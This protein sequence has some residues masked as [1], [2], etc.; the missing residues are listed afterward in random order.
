MS[1]EVDYDNLAR[2]VTVLKLNDS[3]VAR[4]F[5][6]CT[7]YRLSACC[8]IVD[9]TSFR[10]CCGYPPVAPESHRLSSFEFGE[11]FHFPPAR[12]CK[13]TKVTLSTTR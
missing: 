5:G 10:H 7:L 3:Q 4:R 6:F 8:G 1:E 9:H 11:T 2:L 13:E 12:I